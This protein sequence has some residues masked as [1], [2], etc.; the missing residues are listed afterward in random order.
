MTNPSS[1]VNGNWLSRSL[2]R[3]IAATVWISMVVVG[4]SR[5]FIAGMLGEETRDLTSAIILEGIS[6]L[7]NIMVIMFVV[8]LSATKVV[9]RLNEAMASLV[10]GKLDVD[11][12]EIDRPDEFGHMARALQVFKETAIEAESLRAAQEKERAAAQKRLKDEMLAL[13]D[14]LDTAVQNTVTA[15]VKRST[16]MSDLATKMNSAVNRV[17]AAAQD[18]STVSNAATTNVE[19]VAGASEELSASSVEIGQQVKQSSTIASKAVSESEKANLTIQGLA[20]AADKIS[21]VV[22]LISDI[23]E[24]TNLLALN[25]TIEAARAG[26]AGKG[27][28]VVASEVKNLANQTA[29]A[30]EEIS[31][32]ING[33]Q[34]A[35]KGAVVAIGDIG[36]IIG[37]INE[38]ASAIA[39]AVDEQGA[40]T[41]EIARNVKEA[42]EG[43]EA[44][45]SEMVNVSGEIGEAGQMSEI[46]KATADDVSAEV[47][48]LQAQLT[49]IVRESVAG[50]RRD[51][52]RQKVPYQARVKVRDEWRPCTVNDISVSGAEVEAVPTISAGQDVLFEIPDFGEITASVTRITD[53]SNALQFDL[54][55]ETEWR[56]KE[57]LPES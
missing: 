49:R 32:Q 6:E 39:A 26:E 8:S 48:E 34:G 57:V 54:D 51:Y 11:V 17:N 21:E 20:D 52:P 28:A 27:F 13:S 5:L 25:A 18:V 43:T 40:A 16:Q 9:D 50:N 41:E 44:V 30:T 47:Q 56:L 29:K 1:A 33:M 46:V 22:T 42:A 14:E 15:I 7:I 3:K 2:S 31:Q 53:N 35:T 4:G 19:A 36:S 38:I 23:A 37:D 55:A 12:P 45:S 10:K 24:Q